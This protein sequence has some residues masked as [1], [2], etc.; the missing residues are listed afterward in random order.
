MSCY[1]TQLYREIGGC[2]L[3]S[4]WVQWWNYQLQGILS[5]LLKWLLKSQVYVRKMLRS[6]TVP[7][8]ITCAHY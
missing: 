8:K 3:I 1:S 5:N 7:R 6:Q 4:G 2:E